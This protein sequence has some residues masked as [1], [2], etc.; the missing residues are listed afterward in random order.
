M[1]KNLNGIEYDYELYRKNAFV[2]VDNKL[3]ESDLHFEAMIDYLV[4]Y[5]GYDRETLFDLDD[6]EI[7]D[8]L[9]E[10]YIIGEIACIEGELITVVYDI[11]IDIVSKVKK[12]Y[13]NKIWYI[14]CGEF[15]KELN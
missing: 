11:D 9:L 2:I 4:E 14:K 8:K 13:N 3:I 6:F 5:H 7:K 15:L 1:V 10:N 12:F